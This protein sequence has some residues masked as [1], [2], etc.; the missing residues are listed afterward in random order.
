MN[1][2]IKNINVQCS[3]RYADNIYTYADI[4]QSN[5]ML[6]KYVAHST[7]FSTRLD[8][9]III[10]PYIYRISDYVQV[11]IKSKKYGT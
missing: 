3:V 2:F 10:C 1:T 6:K 9:V 4:V 7:D 8:I 5:V 11:L